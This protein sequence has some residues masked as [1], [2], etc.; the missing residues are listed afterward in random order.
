[1]RWRFAAFTLMGA[2][3]PPFLD[4]QGSR[5]S[6]PAGVTV[7]PALLAASLPSRLLARQAAEPD[8]QYWAS[9][10]IAAANWFGL[11]TAQ[12]LVL[13]ALSLGLQW[14]AWH[15]PIANG[16]FDAIASPDLR[17]SIADTVVT[18]APDGTLRLAYLAPQFAST[19]A[20]MLAR[21]RCYQ[22][23]SPVRSS[24]HLRPGR[25]GVPGFCFGILAFGVLLADMRAL[26]PR[27]FGRRRSYY[28]R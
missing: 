21:A 7:W 10:P 26:Q 20:L 28:S 14:A 6:L 1:V 22:P 12:V 19:L 8:S 11:R 27:S 23:T 24:E 16:I 18:T 3:I 2:L 17:Y 5:G 9:L 4:A 15:S 25:Q 13:L